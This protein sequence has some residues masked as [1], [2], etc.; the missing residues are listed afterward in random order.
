MTITNSPLPI[1]NVLQPICDAMRQG[2]RLVLAAP[3][4]AGKT[5][6]VPLVLAGLLHSDRIIKG[7]ILL[8]EPRRVAARMA[9]ERMAAGIGEKL[10][11][12]VGLTTRVDRK[13][14]GKTVIE[15]IT[16]GLFTRRILADPELSGI[17]AVIFDEFHER[18]LNMDLGLALALDAQDALRDDLRLLI[19]SATLDT[20]K[21]A[22]AIDAPVV[23]SQGRAYPVETRYLGRSEERLHDRVAKT[24]RSALD[25]DDGSILV[26]LP[27]AADIR[28]VAEAL[29]DLPDEITVA[30]LYGALSPKEQDIAVSPSKTGKRKVVLATDI[31]ESALTIEGVTI[32]IDAGLARQADTAPGGIGTRLTTVKA[33]LASVDQRRGRAGR[34]APGICYRLWDEAATWG[35]TR[36]PD[37]EIKRSHLDGLVLALAEWGEAD[38]TNL[39]WLDTPPTGRLEAARRE[40]TA[41]GAID[42]AGLTALG[43]EMSKFPLAPR[44]AA[45]IARALPGPERALAA[46]IAAIS[47]E[48]GIGGNSPDLNDRLR[49]FQTDRSP[50]ARRLQ[51]QAARWSKDASPH[52][53]PGELLAK[54][55]PMNIARRRS[56]DSDTYL[57]ASGSAARLGKD[58][59]IS[60]DWLVVIDMTGSAK[61]GFIA[62]ACPID[63]ATAL[64]YGQIEETETAVFDA[65]TRKVAAR[66]IKRIGAIILSE[67]PLPKPSNEAIATSIMEAIASDGW[68][69]IGASETI[70]ALQKRTSLLEQSGIVEDSIEV[71]ATIE[72]DHNLWLRPVL[73][74]K[75]VAVTPGDIEQAF[76]QH[77]DWPLQQAL[78]KETPKSFT[79][80]SGQNAE[81]DYLDERAP[82][83]SARAQAFFGLSVHP[84]I[85]AERIPMTLELLSP[86]R[87]PVAATQNI[88]T[89]WSAGYLDMVKDMRG[90]YPKHDWPADPANAKAHEGKTK[91]RLSGG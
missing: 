44:F 63:E 90:R 61:A 47:S 41:L 62:L 9:A 78:E 1:D 2:N 75:G 88:A 72:S 65:T 37:P 40:L 91:K 56:A 49:R 81:I 50:R 46:Q 24:I 54:T 5:T 73:Q 17:G 16:D 71:F 89:F 57:L 52:G 48:R 32:V 64:Q 66:K 59:P 27:G 8:L 42:A 28:R 11:G 82:L 3:P 26:F 39:T 45:L 14:S 70:A 53:D 22:G 20:E 10:G 58:T 33:S 74:Q 31:A 83:I 34:T 51:A 86:A 85:C 76:I 43:K 12:Q 7:K 84:N 67:A 35:L 38:V 15:V 60:A 69:V 55:W 30:P 29:D 13:V 25:R 19:M 21:V 23:E 18:R 4:G 87:R 79:L 77:I 6:R 80:P 36:A 68:G